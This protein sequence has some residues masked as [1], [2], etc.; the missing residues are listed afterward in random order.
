MRRLIAVL[1][2]GASTCGSGQSGATRY[3]N[4]EK[5]TEGERG[6]LPFWMSTDSMRRCFAQGFER[7]DAG[8]KAKQAFSGGA[9]ADG[10]IGNLA[11]GTAVQ[12]LSSSPEC[13]TLAK[14]R[15][16]EGEHKDKVGCVPPE[17]LSPA[18]MP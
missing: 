4:I 7:L 3:V 5:N 18:R 8:A 9:C 2:L 17:V 14:V 10:R 1:A 12:P 11:H 15:V 13:N 16:L 6:A